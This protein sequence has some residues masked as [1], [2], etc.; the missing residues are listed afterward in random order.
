MQ[1]LG[2]EGESGVGD[3]GAGCGQVG[4][5]TVERG[6]LINDISFFSFAAESVGDEGATDRTQQLCQRRGGRCYVDEDVLAL[7]GRG[8]QNFVAQQRWKQESVA[9]ADGCGEE[10]NYEISVG[11][12]GHETGYQLG[13]GGVAAILLRVGDFGVGQAMLVIDGNDGEIF[14]VSDVTGEGFEVGD[15]QIDP[16]FV[17]QI[18]QVGEAA[19]GLRGRDQILRDGAFVAHAIVEIGEAEAVDFRDVE[20]RLQVLQATVEGRDV[21]VV[22]LG[23]EMR[24]DFFGAGGVARAFAVDSVEDVG[25]CGFAMKID[26]ASI[27]RRGRNYLKNGVGKWVRVPA[28]PWVRG[29]SP[30]RLRSGQ[31]HARRTKASV[32]T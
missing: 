28:F 9:L 24:E 21:D 30:L 12:R 6:L 1:S 23:D 22:S 11:V 15:D 19:G 18:F 20:I 4:E 17:D 3:D 7:R 13:R 29:A 32:A 31:A 14:L 16:P 5:E 27:P 25:Q 10:G 26:G 8:L 2:N